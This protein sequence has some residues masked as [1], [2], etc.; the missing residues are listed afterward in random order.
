[1]KM[2]KTLVELATEIQRRSEAKKDLVAMTSSVKMD[3]ADKQPVLNLVDKDGGNAFSFGMNAIAHEQVAEYLKI[4]R[5]YYDRMRAEAPDLLVANANEWLH[6]NPEKR[7][8]RTL[9]N[10]VRAFMSSAYRPME[11][12]Q[13][14]EAVLPALGELNVHVISAEITDR[15]MYIKAV[16]KSIAKDVALS[17]LGTTHKRFDT[18]SPAIVI[19]NSEVGCGALSIETGVWTGGCT[20]MA[21]IQQKSMRK[22]H[23]GKRHDIGEEMYALLSDQTRRLTDAAVWAQ[24]RDVVKAAFEKAQFDAYCDKLQGLTAQAI[25]DPVQIVELTG[26]RFGLNEGERQSVLKHLIKGADLSRYGLFNAITRTAE[27]QDSYDRA[28]DLERLGGTIVELPKGEW[29]QLAMAA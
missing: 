13:L 25:E 28:T 20:N 27:D 4:P 12:E 6:R 16:D 10:N 15:R 5:A 2:G 14:A 19:A 9:D 24:A 26:K 23:V 1:M 11:N 17:D 7:M 29:Q 21:I 3:L 22:Y 18:L 8:I